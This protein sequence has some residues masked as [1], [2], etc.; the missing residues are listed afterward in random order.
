MD[1]ISSFEINPETPA[2][3]AED[4]IVSLERSIPVVR[5]FVKLVKLVNETKASGVNVDPGRKN[6]HTN[7]IGFCFPD[8][9]GWGKSTCFKTYWSHRSNKLQ[10]QGLHRFGFTILSGCWVNE[11]HGFATRRHQ[12]RTKPWMA[13]FSFFMRKN[14][15]GHDSSANAAARFRNRP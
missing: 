11:M 5:E 14:C 7:T 1:H 3:C 12:K 4:F 9:P 10:N 15:L 2:Q 8:I 13:W 6:T